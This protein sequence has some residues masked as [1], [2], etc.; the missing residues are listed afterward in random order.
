M[1]CEWRESNGA[2]A[3][4]KLDSEAWMVI[5]SEAATSGRYTS[6]APVGRMAEVRA[7][8]SAAAA[9]PVR[10]RDGW[11]LIVAAR[12]PNALSW[13][14]AP[15][16]NCDTSIDGL[17]SRDGGTAEQLF[18]SRTCCQVSHCRRRLLRC[19]RALGYSCIRPQG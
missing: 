1:K 18:R 8:R 15:G 3:G 6:I 12:V 13:M 9:R 16:V 7:G 4:P 2:S 10:T 17:P 19:R 5:A 11:V 14:N